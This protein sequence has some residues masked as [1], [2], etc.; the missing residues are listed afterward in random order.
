MYLQ[1]P[2]VN[3]RK[4]IFPERLKVNLGG[5]FGLV[6]QRLGNPGYIR[7]RLLQHVRIGVAGHVGGE[8][9]AFEPDHFG[10]CFQ[11]FI[12]FLVDGLPAMGF[13]D[14]RPMDSIIK[15]GE[16]VVARS[17]LVLVVKGEDCYGLFV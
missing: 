6:A 8:L 10:D 13:L 5:L 7:T 12:D 4:F 3:F 11:V 9:Y 17:I 2:L 14:F 15:N 1:H 16:T